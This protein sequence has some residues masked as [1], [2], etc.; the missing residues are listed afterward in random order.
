MIGR[1]RAPITVVGDA[2]QQVDP[3]AWFAGWDQAANMPPKGV[4]TR[5]AALGEMAALLHRMRTEPGL[6]DQL[7]RAEDEPLSDDE[8]RRIRHEGRP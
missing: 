1:T 4:E 6:K 3:T 7:A 5:A 8:I 2:A